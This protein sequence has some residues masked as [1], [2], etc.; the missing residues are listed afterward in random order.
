MNFDKALLGQLSVALVTASTILYWR[1]MLLRRIK[2][3]L[4]TWLIWGLAVGIAAAGRHVEHAGPGAWSMAAMS[5]SCLSI[6]LLSLRYGERDITRGD[7]V[8]LLACLAAVPLW[9]FTSNALAAI[10]LVT[11]I[12]LGGYYPTVRKSWLRPQEEATYNFAGREP[13]AHAGDDADA[14]LHPGGEQPAHRHD[15]VAAG[16]WCRRTISTQQPCTEFL[17]CAAPAW[18]APTGPQRS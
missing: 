4:Y 14:K 11:A 7:L 17:N 1:L 9:Y 2:P 10:V 16:R 15:L 3:H 6:A 13:S 8:A 18:P 12:D 5:L